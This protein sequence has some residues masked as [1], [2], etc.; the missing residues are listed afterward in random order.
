MQEADGGK[1]E[2]AELVAQL[3]GQ[4]APMLAEYFGLVVDEQARTAGFQGFRVSGFQGFRVS[5]LCVSGGGGRGF[6]RDVFTIAA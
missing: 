2:L 4:K 5:G 6:D 3:L 1:G